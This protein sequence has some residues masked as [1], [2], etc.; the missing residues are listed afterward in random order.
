MFDFWF[1][2][3]TFRESSLRSKSA[4]WHKFEMVWLLRWPIPV[5]RM[6]VIYSFKWLL[7][8]V[9]ALRR[10][11]V[12]G[13]HPV[14]GYLGYRSLLS[15]QTLMSSWKALRSCCG[16]G[17]FWS[18]GRHCVHVVDRHRFI[19][20]VLTSLS[21]VVDRHRFDADPDPTLHFDADPDPDSNQSFTHG[22]KSEFF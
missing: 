14:G 2:T 5:G 1:S 15:F 7:P 10:R 20:T 8:V 18:Y 22:R 4:A 6:G 13:Q 12:G 3:F 9:A 19:H 21:S 17:S 16:S 11:G